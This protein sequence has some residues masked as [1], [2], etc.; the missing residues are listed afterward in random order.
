MFR[1]LSGIVDLI[2]IIGSSVVEFFYLFCLILLFI[3]VFSLLGMQIFGG[4][5]SFEEGVP[6]S[7]FDKFHYAFVT[8]FQLLSMENWDSVL[9]SSLRFSPVS[10]IFLIFWIIIGN[11]VLLNIFLAILL[12]G[13][14]N[15]DELALRTPDT[16]KTLMSSRLFKTVSSKLKEKRLRE[17][18]AKYIADS[19][20]DFENIEINDIED[21]ER[22]LHKKTRRASKQFEGISCEKSFYLFS[23]TNKIR[24]FLYKM[25]TNS[26]FDFCILVIILLNS[27]KLVFDT[28]ILESEEQS[29]EVRFSTVAD[30]VFTVLFGLELVCKAVS[31]GF[32]NEE[33]SY[34]SDVWNILDFCIVV[35]SVVDLSLASFDISAIKVLR[36]LRTLRPLRFITHNI[37][38]KIIVLALFSSIFAIL[39]VLG[40]MALI[41]L[42]FAILGVSLF[43]GKLY[44]CSNGLAVGQTEC[45]KNG[46][47]WVPL[48]YNF[49]NVFESLSTLFT[50]SSL[51]SWPD[52]M[53]EGVD[54]VDI[55]HELVKDYNPLA[56]YFYIMI[57][58]VGNFF[59]VNVFTAVVYDRFNR[60][61]MTESSALSFLLHKNQITWL[62]IQKL[63]IKSKPRIQSRTGNLHLLEKKLGPLINS[64]TF[65]TIMILVI[66]LNTISMAIVYEGASDSYLESLSLI[67]DICTYIFIFEVFIKILAFGKSYFKDNWN[68]LDFLVVTCSVLSIILMHSIS[69]EVSLLRVAPQLIR[70]IR[71]LRI[72]KL[73]KIFKSL[74][75]IRT[76]V[77]I[78]IFSLPAMLNVLSLMLLIF[79]I[80]AVLGSFLFFNVK[81]GKVIN[82]YF[83]FQNFHSS[84]IMLWRIST[85]ESYTNIMIDIVDHFNSKSYILYF[86]SFIILTTYIFLDLFV[87]VIVDNYNEYH[88]NEES[89]VYLFNKVVKKFNKTW[90]SFTA[91]NGGVKIPYRQLPEFLVLIGPDLGVSKDVSHKTLLKIIASLDLELDPYGYV[92]YN[93]ML[94]SL[95]KRKYGRKLFTLNKQDLAK[96]YMR[97]EEIVAYKELSKI[98]LKKMK[99]QSRQSTIKEEK[100]NKIRA[101]VS[102][103]ELKPVF[104]AWKMFIALKKDKRKAHRNSIMEDEKYFI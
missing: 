92:Y 62:E 56:A 77:E 55:G 7:N 84:M 8:V 102:P 51:E 36:M 60:A 17:I 48:F 42:I 80:F 104:D 24:V 103:I 86:Y 93:D 15:F 96:K 21:L 65:E 53:Y 13:F 12:Q 68:K 63:I 27:A 71:V 20:E 57:V 69:S 11:F 25:T 75:S 41:F 37:T 31:N 66:I 19:D 44:E 16:K 74:K 67:N 79:F 34:L 40:I 97:K 9:V 22:V 23:K 35:L 73:F 14:Q 6:R 18:E 39:N 29:P 4:N 30:M 91:N 46:Y 90:N 78:L 70:I 94:F 95:M 26:K 82:D 58:V 49:D 83:N 98:R 32:F 47:S 99:I 10:C 3:V 88:K 81:S 5:F 59:M 89:T 87:S 33:G 1:Y 72:S 52:R 45:I 50:I 28:Y 61:R 54:A 2:T 64:K 43:G 76:L 100:I 101:F 38:M 85:G